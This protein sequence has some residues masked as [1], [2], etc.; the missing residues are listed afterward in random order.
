MIVETIGVPTMMCWILHKSNERLNDRFMNYID[1]MTDIV[2]NNTIALNKLSER[3][4][5]LEYTARNGKDV[6]NVRSINLDK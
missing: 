1:K 6:E 2:N 4:S 3:I 5:I